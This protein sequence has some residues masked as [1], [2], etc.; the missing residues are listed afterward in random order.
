MFLLWRALDISLLGGGGVLASSCLFHNL[1]LFYLKCV[2]ISIYYLANWV[3]GQQSKTCLLY[4]E[5][6]W[7]IM[8][9]VFRW[10]RSPNSA[11]ASL[12]GPNRVHWEGFKWGSSSSSGSGCV[13]ID[14]F[15]FQHFLLIF[16]C[17]LFL[18][19]ACWLCSI[20]GH[21]FQIVF[22][23]FFNLIFQ[24][25]FRFPM[26][27]LK[28]HAGSDLEGRVSHLPICGPLPLKHLEASI[29]AG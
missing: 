13:N 28:R 29:L 10:K 1:N 9:N 25:F 4:F 7:S 11:S 2:S 6:C 16:P 23:L 19:L 12:T 15:S 18:S 27:L 21:R 22:D 5:F 17:C 14:R 26:F 8:L 3:K 24:S 20:A